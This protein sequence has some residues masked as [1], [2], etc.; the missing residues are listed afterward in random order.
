[1]KH[2]RWLILLLPSLAF[3]Q[4]GGLGPVGGP[5]ISGTP[6]T[7]H[8]VE[9]LN[10]VTLEDA[11]A[12]C[13]TGGGGSGTVTSAALSDGSTVPIYTISGSPITTSGTLTFSF[14]TEAANFVL[15]GPASGST[16]VEP[17]FRALNAADVTAAL[18]SPPPIGATTASTGAFTT[19]GATGNLTTNVT[20]ST[21]C[22]HASTAGVVS[23]TGSDCGSGG[24]P[25]FSSITTGSNT[26]AT[27]TV[28]TG[29]TITSSGTGVINATQLGGATFAAPGAIGGTTA[30]AG[31][32]TTLTS[33]GAA[34]INASNNAAT[35]IGTGTTTSNVTIGGVSNIV[36]VGGP[37]SLTNA[38]GISASSWTTAGLALSGTAATLTDSTASGTVAIEAA[39]AL[40]VYTIAAT[41][42]GVTI[43]SLVGLYLPTPVAGTHVTGTN[44]YS[45]YTTGQALIGGKITGSAGATLTGALT[46]NN[47]GSS[48]TNIGTASYTGTITIGNSSTTGAT[49]LAGL[50]SSSAA[51]TGTVCIGTG[52][53]LSY[54]TTTTCLLSDGRLKDN[55]APLDIGL[56]EV[57]KLKPVSYDLKPEVNP[58]HLGKQVG[59][60][61]QDVIKVDPRLAAL[62]QSGPQ[63][64]TPSGVRYEQLTAVLVKAIQEQQIQITTLEARLKKL[65]RKHP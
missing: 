9:W 21:Q 61:A 33:N 57:L 51:Q 12:A 32:F 42:S 5:A 1:M 63:K 11:G 44:V 4:A 10:A 43:T 7:G 37:I 14:N 27:M 19:L 55:I 6:T 26:T 38:G 13:G 45:L 53:V 35:N 58:T 25:A 30:A 22:L 59:L 48:A 3:G 39:A 60:I 36:D 17:T 62:Y 46:L 41:T 50:A 54:D 29:G 40:P 34:N 15:A 24:S 28:G 49:V 56:A 23:G 64:G 16:A 8:C 31:A 2:L 18:V 20:G 52:N 65:E 47:S